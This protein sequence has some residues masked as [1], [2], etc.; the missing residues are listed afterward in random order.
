MSHPATGLGGTSDLHQTL[1][2]IAVRHLGIVTPPSC[3]GGR[4]QPPPVDRAAAAHLGFDG[5]LRVRPEPTAPCSRLP[6][7]DGAA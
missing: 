2:T 7:L 5:V 6:L 4:A 1:A 3:R